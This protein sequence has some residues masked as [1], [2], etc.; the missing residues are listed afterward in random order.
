MWALAIKLGDKCLYLVD[1]GRF[2]TGNCGALGFLWVFSTCSPHHF[3][4]TWGPT[5]RVL[6]ATSNMLCTRVENTQSCLDSLLSS[7][8]ES[9]VICV[10]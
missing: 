4:K 3:F 6:P 1:L 8:F 10:T 5:M 2:L 9:Y 7:I